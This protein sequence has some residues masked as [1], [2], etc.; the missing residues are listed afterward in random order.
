MMNCLNRK[1]FHHAETF[2][3]LYPENYIHLP[4]ILKNIQGILT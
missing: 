4:E 2:N 1:L 3:Q